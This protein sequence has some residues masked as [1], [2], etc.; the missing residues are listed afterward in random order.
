MSLMDD[1]ATV[2]D[3]CGHDSKDDVLD[4]IAAPIADE[5]RPASLGL[6]AV[7]IA[8]PPPAR[9]AG[10]LSGRELA[11]L[12]LAIAGAAVVTLS[13]L[14]L[15]GTTATE[16]AAT[17]VPSVVTTAP[18]HPDVR[19]ASLAEP[20]WTSANSKLWVGSAK[21]SVAFE[22]PADDRVAVWTRYVQ[23]LLVVRCVAG[24]VEVFVY[25]DTAAKI[26]PQTEDHTVRYALDGEAETTERW[27]DAAA[28]DGLFARDG[29]AL[30]ARLAKAKT[31]RFGFTPHNAEPVTA[32]F[33]VAGL[34]ELLGSASRQCAPPQASARLATPSRH[35]GSR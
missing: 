17:P 20:R 9:A 33:N 3:R 23:P 18:S 16:A 34:S 35:R 11:V 24:S 5:P 27:T 26:E 6:P 14:M 10:P 25:T 29:A 32:R 13:L 2:C 4:V 1:G 31:M 21:N 28:H 12:L 19:K 22:L 30:A 15:R 7:V 8:P